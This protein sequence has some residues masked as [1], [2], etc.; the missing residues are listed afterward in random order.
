RLD[1]QR[2]R[3]ELEVHAEPDRRE[4]LERLGRGDRPRG[5]ERGVRAPDLVLERGAV[6]LREA[7][8]HVALVLDERR[9]DLRELLQDLGLADAE[10]HLVADLEEVALGLRALA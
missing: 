5:A 8:A 10:T 4:H 6:A 9:D 3:Q 1:R 2:L 7:L